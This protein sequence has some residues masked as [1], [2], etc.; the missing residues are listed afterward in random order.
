MKSYL[1]QPTIEQINR[2]SAQG[3]TPKMIAR[4]FGV[5]EVDIVQALEDDFERA[6]MPTDDAK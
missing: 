6:T 5:R 1:I 3:K 4:H 2:L